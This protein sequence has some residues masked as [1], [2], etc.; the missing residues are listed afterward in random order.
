VLIK[1]KNGYI[2]WEKRRKLPE[3]R[4]AHITEAGIM[5]TPFGIVPVGYDHK[6]KTKMVKDIRPFH[7]MEIFTHLIDF[8]DR[9]GESS[10]SQGRGT[11]SDQAT[12]LLD[13]LDKDFGDGRLLP[14]AHGIS[15]TARTDQYK[16]GFSQLLKGLFSFIGC[17]SLIGFVGCDGQGVSHMNTEEI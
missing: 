5:G 4:F 16:M 17:G 15:R 9:E 3:A 10:H 1:T 12:P 2:S 14:L 11:G 8:I 13:P 6:I 7:P